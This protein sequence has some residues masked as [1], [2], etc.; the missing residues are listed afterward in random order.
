MRRMAHSA[1]LARSGRCAAAA[2]G[3][4]GFRE[5]RAKSLI[6]PHSTLPSSKRDT[7]AAAPHPL[8]GITRNMHGKSGRAAKPAKGRRFE[9]TL[10]VF[11]KESLNTHTCECRREF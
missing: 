6:R 5:R 2:G 4:I 9:A 3:G 8:A 7:D 1:P 10:V 11:K